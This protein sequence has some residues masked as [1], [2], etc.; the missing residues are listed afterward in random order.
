VSVVL[1]DV[2]HQLV[3]TIRRLKA[4]HASGITPSFGQVEA[5]FDLGEQLDTAIRLSEPSLPCATGCGR[6]AA[7]KVETRPYC[8][9]CA[10]ALDVVTAQIAQDAPEL[11]RQRVDAMVQRREPWPAAVTSEGARA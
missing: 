3:G 4:Q 10:Q 11:A 1:Q 5:L 8:A 6:P 9:R 2:G 7:R